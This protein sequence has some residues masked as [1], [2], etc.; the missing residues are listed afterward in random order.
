MRKNEAL[1]NTGALDPGAEKLLR[2]MKRQAERYTGGDSSSI[3][4]ETARELLESICFCLGVEADGDLP[5]GDL[6]AAF[7]EGLERIEKKLAWGR[8]LWAAVRDHMPPVESRSMEDTVESI[9]TFWERYDYRL[10][11]HLVPCDIDYQLSIPVSEQLR[12]VDYVN[13][14]LTRLA[15]ENQFLLRFSGKREDVILRRY[16]PDYRGLLVNLFEPV[17]AVV[18]GLELLGR[19][20]EGLALT[21]EDLEALDGLFRNLP[22]RGLENLLEQGTRRLAARLALNGR[23]SRDYLRTCGRALAPRIAAARDVGGMEGIFLPLE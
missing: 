5:G 20:P 9:G 4:L 12:G 23:E 3:P 14:Y 19:D 7:R 6:E 11:A 2:L 1:Q 8:A 13:A 17:F 10:F 22:R 15:V 21:R 16:C 18:L